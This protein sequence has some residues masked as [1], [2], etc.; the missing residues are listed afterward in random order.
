MRSAD[1]VVRVAGVQVT[2]RLGVGQD[3]QHERVQEDN[4]EER[5]DCGE[6]D[7]SASLR[8]PVQCLRQSSQDLAPANAHVGA[9]VGQQAGVT[10]DVHCI[11][12]RAI[13]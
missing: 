10:L 2:D 5:K 9:Q 12:R 7:D 3:N 6:S 4:E 1:K 8:E 11:A 13:P